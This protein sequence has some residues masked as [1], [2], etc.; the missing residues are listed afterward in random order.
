MTEAGPPAEAEHLVAEV[1]PPT[2]VEHLIDPHSTNSWNKLIR[3]TQVMLSWYHKTLVDNSNSTLTLQHARKLWFISAMPATITALKAGRLRELDIHQVDGVQVIQGRAASG[4]QKFF[5]QN[6]LPVIMGSTR[7]AFLIMLDANCQD[8]AGRDITLATSRH[9][10][11][12]VNSKK[13]SKNIV[14]NCIRCRFLRKLIESQKMAPIP[15]ILQV[16]SPPFSNIGIDLLGPLVVKPMVNKRATMKVWVVL[17]VCLNAKAISMELAP[18]YSTDD[19]LLAY[20][21]HVSQRGTPS[22]VHSDRGSQLV[23]AHKD[24]TDDPLK[25]DW[26]LISEST[27]SQGT[28]WQFAP[29]GGQWRNG[30]AVALVKKF[31]RSFSHLYQNTRLNYAELNCAIKRIANVL[32][33][34]PVSA[35]RTNSFSP[36]ED[37]LSPLTPNMLITGRSQSGPPRDYIDVADPHLRKTILE[38]L[39]APWW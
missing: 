31:K 11:W 38:E 20:S 5:G 24:L 13:L 16:P 2:G 18:G 3:F 30:S 34:R 15:D 36:D 10:A 29:A 6:S 39:D 22:F 14:R 25:Y 9:T 4:M 19:F 7:V 12:I 35:Q 32:N 1:D 26:D 37:F 21:A 23:A 8:H 17:F 33:D 28:T 27:A